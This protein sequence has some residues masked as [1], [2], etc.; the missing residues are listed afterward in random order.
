MLDGK[1]LEGLKL[2]LDQMVKGKDNK[3]PLDASDFA[4]YFRRLDKKFGK[5]KKKQEEEIIRMFEE[6]TVYDKDNSQCN[7]SILQKSL[8][9]LTHEIW[10]AVIPIVCPHCHAKSSS[11]RKDGYTKFFSKPLSEKLRN[12]IKQ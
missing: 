3:K 4:T 5:L 10:S 2:L 11:F 9:E 8:K 6:C 1:K 7:T 12:Q